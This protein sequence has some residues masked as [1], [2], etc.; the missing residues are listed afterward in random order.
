[1][2][3]SAHPTAA[4]PRP[5][6]R[7]G[8]AAR[9]RA[10]GAVA[11][12]GDRRRRQRRPAQQLGGQGRRSPGVERLDGRHHDRALVR[13]AHAAGPGL[14]Q[15]ARLPGAARRQLPAR[16]P[17]RGLPADAAGQGRAAVLPVPA[18][19]P[20]HGRLLH[21]LGRH[22]RDGGAVGGGRAPVHRLPVPRL[23]RRGPVHQPAGRRRARR[24]RDLGGGRR[25][26]RRPAGGT[27]VGGGP[28]P[29]VAGPGRARHPD[30]AA[31]GHVRGGRLAGR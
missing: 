3:S 10:A 31:A 9:Y 12:G 8:R 25:P 28:E 6:L 21:R 20:G 17:R 7:R 24:G 19:G 14:G 4:T 29:A 18:E 26:G 1:M 16:R 11:L 30:R 5:A 22:R 27:A 13:R 2:I 15:A 23:A